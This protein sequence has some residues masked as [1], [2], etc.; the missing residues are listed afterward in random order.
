MNVSMKSW[1]SWGSHKLFWSPKLYSFSSCASSVATC[2]TS[3]TLRDSIKASAELSVES[4][5]WDILLLFGY[6]KQTISPYS[7]MMSCFTA[8]FDT[9]PAEPLF[10]PS[11]M[12]V[13]LCADL[14][15]SSPR[16]KN[17]AWK[18]SSV[19]LTESSFLRFFIISSI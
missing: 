17:Q 9:I 12:E 1:R 4:A 13:R 15:K 18:E 3:E 11:L 14:L 7:S 5:I 19:A 6:V 8:L 16:A 10:S 2:W